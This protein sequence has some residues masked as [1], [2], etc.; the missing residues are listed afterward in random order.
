MGK[1]Q[2]FA[3][4]IT[5]EVTAEHTFLAYGD[6]KLK[7]TLDEIERL[8]IKRDFHNA[9]KMEATRQRNEMVEEG[10][11]LATAMRVALKEHLGPD[12]E[13]LT[14]YGIQPFRSKK[15]AKKPA[16]PPEPPDTPPA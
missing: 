2:R 8:T 11:R 15:R 3:N 12:S 14:Q 5:P 6:A 10:S 9:R 16:P 7:H 4:S 1:L 13:Q